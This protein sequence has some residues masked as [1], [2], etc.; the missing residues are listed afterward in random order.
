VINR[1]PELVAKKFGKRKVVY[2]EIQRESGLSYPTVL[3]WMKR[4]V[5]RADFEVLEKWCRYLGVQPGDILVY[6]EDGS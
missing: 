3:S 4:H 6:E 5:D 1:V 2:L